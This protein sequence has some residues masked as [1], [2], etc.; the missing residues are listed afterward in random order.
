L[1]EIHGSARGCVNIPAGIG[2]H[3][4]AERGSHSLEKVPVMTGRSRRIEDKK[5]KE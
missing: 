5:K 4:R 1:R 3:S 2:D